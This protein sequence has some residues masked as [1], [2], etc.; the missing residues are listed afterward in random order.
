MSI[1][2]T[3]KRPDN[4]I[5]SNYLGVL[6]C[7]FV[8]LL[9]LFS[10]PAGYR[11][12]AHHVI[13]DAL[14]DESGLMEL[15][16]MDVLG[17]DEFLP[18]GSYRPQQMQDLSSREFDVAVPLGFGICPEA[19]DMTDVDVGPCPMLGAV[20]RGTVFESHEQHIERY[21]EQE[22]MTCA[23]ARR[24]VVAYQPQRLVL[25]LSI[26][27]DDVAGCPVLLYDALP[28]AR[29]DLGS[30]STIRGGKRN[31]GVYFMWMR[32]NHGWIPLF[33]YLVQV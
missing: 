2:H 18:Y 11:A 32:I 20:A 7:C 3:Q 14:Q 13:V 27:P 19:F 23:Q 31:D 5:I 30:L 8:I 29:Q 9:G 17:F 16:K 12:F 6:F 1:L 22:G 24:V 15:T 25:V 10:H 4:S 28:A 21:R 26:V 33:H